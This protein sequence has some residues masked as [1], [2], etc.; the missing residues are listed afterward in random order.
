MRSNVRENSNAQI[1]GFDL[2]ATVNRL[3]QAGKLIG[4]TGHGYYNT[5]TKC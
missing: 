5:S 1:A 3:S 4:P 2:G